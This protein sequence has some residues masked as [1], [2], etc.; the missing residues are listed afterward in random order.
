MS[1][2]AAQ[3]HKRYVPLCS[4]VVQ[5]LCPTV[6][7]S[8]TSVMSHCAA[9]WHK[10]YVPLCSTVAQAL[11]PTVQHSGTSVMS[12]CAAQ[13]H[14]QH[15]PL[16]STVAQAICLYT[17]RTNFVFN[18]EFSFIHTVVAS[19]CVTCRDLFYI[20][21]YC[22][23][24]HKVALCIASNDAICKYRNA[25]ISHAVSSTHYKSSYIQLLLR[26]I[27]ASRTFWSCGHAFRSELAS[28]RYD[29]I[30]SSLH[31]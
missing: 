19:C 8:G 10:R 9:Q 17:F 13:W 3:W 7:H 4:T 31:A 28:P 18:Y 6:Q 25:A 23:T 21:L 26:I 20:T 2:C 27:E 12:H 16:C 30:I 15:V 5:A 14:K 22:V 11:C 1:H 24:Q 29:T